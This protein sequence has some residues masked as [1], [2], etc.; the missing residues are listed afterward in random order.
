MCDCILLGW[1]P[2]H[3]IYTANDDSQ[4]LLHYKSISV[5]CLAL[6]VSLLA[7]L[8]YIC[9]ACRTEKIVQQSKSSNATIYILGPGRQSTA[10]KLISVSQMGDSLRCDMHTGSVMPSIA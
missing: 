7:T 2:G 3:I 5:S 9:R 4:I 1:T 10:T 6:T 8:A